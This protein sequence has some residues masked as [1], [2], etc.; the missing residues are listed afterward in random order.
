MVTFFERHGD[1][2]KS[3]FGKVRERPWRTKAGLTNMKIVQK[4]DEA[5]AVLRRLLASRGSQL[6]QEERLRRLLH[7][8]E[9][10]GKGGKASR[11]HLVSLIAEI[12]QAVCEEC[13]KK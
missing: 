8:L 10:E 11:S 7:R 12:S 1:S 4:V 9:A 3:L 6:V 13:L 2:E 5:A